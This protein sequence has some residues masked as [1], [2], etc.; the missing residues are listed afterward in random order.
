MA[1]LEDAKRLW[2]EFGDVIVDDADNIE[3]SW[4]VQ[5]LI[6]T[7]VFPAGTNK[8]EIW[9]WFEETFDVSVATDLHTTS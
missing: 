1:K 3:E 5:G 6:F 8:F 9:H 2:E 7:Q 4:H